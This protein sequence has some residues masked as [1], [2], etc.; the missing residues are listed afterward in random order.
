MNNA[1]PNPFDK[2]FHSFEITCEVYFSSARLGRK[3]LPLHESQKHFNRLD[4]LRKQCITNQ[5]YVLVE[6]SS[7]PDDLRKECY[8]KGFVNNIRYSLVAKCLSGEVFLGSFNTLKIVNA[9][10]ER[11]G[12]DGAV[13]SPYWQISAD[14]LPNEVLN[15]LIQFA[16]ET[17]PREYQ[18]WRFALLPFPDYWNV[19]ECDSLAIRFNNTPWSKEDSQ[20][21]RKELTRKGFDKRFTD[22]VILAGLAGIG[23]LVFDPNGKVIEGL[24]VYN[25]VSEV[26]YLRHILHDQIES[27]TFWL[28]EMAGWETDEAGNTP[29]QQ[30][31]LILE[32]A[33]KEEYL[34]KQ[35][36]CVKE[37]QQNHL[38]QESKK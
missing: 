8:I 4:M 19:G 15:N 32:P 11:C 20:S 23:M 35:A 21:I 22:F 38:N 31:Q 29:E 1:N 28:N 7:I 34:A 26:K 6:D 37:S 17:H 3:V 30:F 27:E 18:A 2:H 33:T 16:F 10:I 12:Y 14:H 9:V 24:P 36:E 13:K 25:T 5:H